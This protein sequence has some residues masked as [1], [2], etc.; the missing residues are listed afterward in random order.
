MKKVYHAMSHRPRIVRPDTN[1][2][3]AAA[4]MRR[5]GVGTLVVA[6]PSAGVW[7]PAD[8]LGIVS[9]RDIVVRAIADG[10]DPE[11]TSVSHAMT[12]P[13]FQCSEND[14]LKAAIEQMVDRGVR[15][16]LVF[17]TDTQEL[18]GILSLDD[19]AERAHIELASEVLKIARRAG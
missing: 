12:T 19:L 14:E 13:V 17:S 4:M 16:L 10:R 1:L 18:R 2:V 5:D 8:I 9:D 7:H 15:R 3:E 11:I 6:N